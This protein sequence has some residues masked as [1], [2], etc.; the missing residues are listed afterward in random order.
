MNKNVNSVASIGVTNL[1]TMSISKIV[2]FAGATLMFI[3]VG[4]ML[5]SNKTLT[6]P[7]VKYLREHINMK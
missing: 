7:E 6:E 4:G 2:T 1:T 5:L 3:G